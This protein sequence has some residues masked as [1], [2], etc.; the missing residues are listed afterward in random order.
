MVNQSFARKFFGDEDRVGR[1]LRP[2][3]R[4]STAPWLTI[5]GVVADVRSDGLDR[6]ALPQLYR[7]LLQASSLQFGLVVR[8]RVQPAS[9]GPSIAREVRSLDP[10]MP[11]YG[12]RQF[13]DIVEG[14]IDPVSMLRAD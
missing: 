2:G 7:A 11:V 12:L 14:S 13:D 8:G 9:I 3:G 10:D 5:V 6:E 1:R 4:Q